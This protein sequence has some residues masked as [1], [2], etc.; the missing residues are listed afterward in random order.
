[1]KKILFPTD[2]SEN[3]KNAFVFALHLAKSIHAEII[4]LH[5][6]QYP[7]VNYME[8]PVYLPEMYEVT[9]LTHFENYKGHVP[10][11]RTIAEAH[12]LEDVK[13]SNV[14]ENGDLIST[15]SEISKKE[16]ID[17]IV[18]GTKGATGLA[19]TFLGSV[20]EKVINS[21]HTLVVAIPEACS[22]KPIKRILFPTSYQVEEIDILKKVLAFANVFHAHVDCLYVAPER[23]PVDEEITENWKQLFTNQALTFHK[24]SSNDFEGT[25]IDFITLHQTDMLSMTTHHRNFFERI[26]E[27]SLS[28]KLIFHAKIPILAVQAQS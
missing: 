1:M 6:Y 11:L 10:V 5:V 22:Y 23:D 15:I 18:M 7:Q 16:H 21:C 27:E 17:Y 2:F 26:F 9:D 3:S 24:V 8:I 13:M 28:R 4:T 19:A 12:Q 14:L 20:T 25:I